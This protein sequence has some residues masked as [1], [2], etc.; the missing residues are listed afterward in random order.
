VK[1]YKYLIVLFVLLS[2]NSSAQSWVWGKQG[3]GN[4]QDE[5]T[6]AAIDKSCNV[7][8]AGFFA[9]TLTFGINV[10]AAKPTNTNVFIVK[11]DS[12][13]NIIWAR[14]S[15]STI[16][17]SIPW[18]TATDT[19][20][21]AYLTGG[22][23]D[24]ISF[25]AFDLSSKNSTVDVPLI[26]YDK[27][28][29]VKWA[30][31]SIING[32]SGGCAYSVA[33]WGSNS[34]YVTGKIYDSLDFGKYKLIGRNT[35]LVKYDSNGNVK[36]A[37]QSTGT[38]TATSSSVASDKTGN[39]YI[40]GYF[41]G[42]LYFGSYK[43]ISSTANDIFLVKY[44]SLGNV[45]WAD[46]ATSSSGNCS[47]NAVTTDLWGN[48]I[49][50]GSFS[51]SLTFGA[52]ILNAPIYGGIFMAKYDLSGKAVWARMGKSLNPSTWS[53]YSITTDIT[54]DIYL[55]GGT[56]K[57]A[58]SDSIIFDYDTLT[59]SNCSDASI[60]AKF[61]TSGTFICGA[62]ITSGGDDQ[63]AIV[64]DA[65][66]RYIYLGGDYWNSNFVFGKDTVNSSLEM[67]F[68]A[69]WQPCE[70]NPQSVNNI[71]APTQ[72]ITLFP[73]PNNG[74]FELKIKNYE[75]GMESTV[76][77][78]NVLGEKVYEETLRQAQ[79]DNKVDISNQSAGL[80]LYRLLNEEGT[81]ISSG[82]FVI[83]K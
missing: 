40:T 74:I 60:V 61:D 8:L 52:Y 36:W 37:K 29:N 11:Y 62:M 69:R 19:F 41:A 48:A 17:F 57:A 58:T 27:N 2:L 35:F 30:E 46:M 9:D 59:L 7:F 75:S 28:G 4:Q 50:T 14:Q 39:I 43:L 70:Q 5:G 71:T 24:T 38:G 6:S 49:I 18:M 55:S 33:T 16:S 10:L 65:T 13:G 78:Y 82:K 42:T 20:G 44:D 47:S 83:Q 73:N 56:T 66:G 23:G 31:Q 12:T 54:G 15:N 64:V 81:L 80:Y 21:N 32:G 22:F 53:G 68:I 63:N 79:G 51:N 34:I 25:G 45:L 1:A 72:N 67:P 26:K 76:E 3:F 77:I